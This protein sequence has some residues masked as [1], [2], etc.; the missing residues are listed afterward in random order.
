MYPLFLVSTINDFGISCYNGHLNLQI[1]K[2]YKVHFILNPT[3]DL[4]FTERLSGN[5]E[6]V[7]NNIISLEIL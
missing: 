2:F 4:P 5:W 3:A 7:S 1:G 6:F